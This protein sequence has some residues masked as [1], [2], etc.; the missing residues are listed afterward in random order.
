MSA[1]WKKKQ[2]VGSDLLGKV[3]WDNH[4]FD[5]LIPVDI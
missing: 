2:F 5:T 3:G 1:T 4:H